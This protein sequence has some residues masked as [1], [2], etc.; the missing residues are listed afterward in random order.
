MGYAHLAPL[1]KLEDN[2]DLNV[3]ILNTARFSVLGR[4]LST[5]DGE[6][7]EEVTERYKTIDSM[8]F[9]GFRQNLE[10][11][12]FEQSLEVFQFCNREE[13][14]SDTESKYMVSKG[15]T[16]CNLLNIS[17]FIGCGSQSLYDEL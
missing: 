6:S 7:A 16:E 2:E 10:S 4:K 9:V 5:D 11:L 1:K 3:I 8:K 12:T 14:S 13:N 15:L 17:D